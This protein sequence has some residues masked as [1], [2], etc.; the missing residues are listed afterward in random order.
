MEGRQTRDSQRDPSLG[1]ACR[2][3][4]GSGKDHG[5]YQE[6]KLMEVV[7]K[8]VKI[9]AP[10]LFRLR[11]GDI[12]I[13]ATWKRKQQHENP[14]LRRNSSPADS[15]NKV[16]IARSKDEPGGVKARDNSRDPP[17]LLFR[18]AA[19]IFQGLT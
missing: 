14:P 2:R 8:P 10:A 19:G 5:L 15:S 18:P 3:S 7:G 16:D 4:M 13:A 6:A 11:P 12:D 17:M 1:E 9:L